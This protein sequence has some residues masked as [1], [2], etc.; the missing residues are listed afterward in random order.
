[1]FSV[2]WLPWEFDGLGDLGECGGKTFVQS[3]GDLLPKESE[4]GE[5]DR[6]ACLGTF[7]MVSPITWVCS[8]VFI[9]N[10]AGFKVSDL[11]LECPRGLEKLDL[12]AKEETR[13]PA[14]TIDGWWSVGDKTHLLWPSPCQD[15]VGTIT[16]LSG[17]KLRD[18]LRAALGVRGGF[19]GGVLCSVLVPFPLLSSEEEA[20]EAKLSIG[21]D[22]SSSKTLASSCK[23]LL[24]SMLL[25]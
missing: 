7:N 19:G 12:G 14:S 23:S 18:M 25:R 24:K 8:F 3:V 17:T 21:T 6:D 15:R 2:M 1:M 10:M 9:S 4:V 5:G 16:I 22:L 20:A 13:D 11:L